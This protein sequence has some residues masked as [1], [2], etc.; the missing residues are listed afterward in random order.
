MT[1]F[2]MDLMEN[3]MKKAAAFNQEPEIESGKAAKTLHLRGIIKARLSDTYYRKT[4]Y[5]LAVT[6]FRSS[7]PII[8]TRHLRG[9][10]KVLLSDTENFPVESSRGYTS[11][12]YV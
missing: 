1:D 10:I 8:K 4:A 12:R 3:L 6:K 9:I 7:K 11:S 5:L 2:D